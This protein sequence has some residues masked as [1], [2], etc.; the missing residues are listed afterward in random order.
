MP[1]NYDEWTTLLREHQQ[2][3]DEQAARIEATCNAHAARLTTLEAATGQRLRGL[4]AQ[5]ADQV[6]TLRLAGETMEAVMAV[7]RRHGFDPASGLSALEWLE[8]VLG[9]AAV[10]WPSVN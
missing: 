4:E 3:L 9:T 5:V 6:E 1:N 7:C 2:A 8:Y 10:G